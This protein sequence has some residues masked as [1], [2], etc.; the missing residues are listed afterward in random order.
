[1]NKKQAKINNYKIINRCKFMFFSQ[2][3]GL[4]P[5]FVTPNSNVQSVAEAHVVLQTHVDN[6]FSG[7]LQLFEIGCA[8]HQDDAVLRQSELA[9]T[10]PIIFMLHHE[11]EKCFSG[12][13]KRSQHFFVDGGCR[14]S[15]VAQ[16]R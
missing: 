8:G 5:L 11:L 13:N 2:V 1:M 12:S 7:L 16:L 3:V 14:V 15:S 9:Y 10:C 6:I 4:Y